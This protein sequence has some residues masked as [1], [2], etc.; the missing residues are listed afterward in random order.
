MQQLTQEPLV[1]S[2]SV[3]RTLTQLPLCIAGRITT[4]ID[5]SQLTLEDLPFDDI[6]DVAVSALSRIGSWLR[7]YASVVRFFSFSA[8]MLVLFPLS[9][10]SPAH[11][12]DT[13]Y[14]VAGVCDCV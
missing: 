4:V 5:S 10:W 1:V 14:D 12:D 9:A 8:P 3:E 13:L 7:I 11:G 2:P 6:P